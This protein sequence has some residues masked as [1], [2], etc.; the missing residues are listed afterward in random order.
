MEERKF[1][2][3]PSQMGLSEESDYDADQLTSIIYVTHAGA[4]DVGSYRSDNL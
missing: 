4:K 2:L 3:V 1:N